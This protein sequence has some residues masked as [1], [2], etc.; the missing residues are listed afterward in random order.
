MGSMRGSMDV[1]YVCYVSVRGSMEEMVRRSLRIDGG[2]RERIDGE[3][4]DRIDGGIG[5]RI[6]GG[7]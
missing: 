6:D 5:E 1:C 7:I 4:S 2:I 3:I